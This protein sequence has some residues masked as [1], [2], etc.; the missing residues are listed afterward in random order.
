MYVFY[1]CFFFFRNA[2]AVEQ[3]CLAATVMSYRNKLNVDY[4]H[5]NHMYRM[6]TSCFHDNT[7]L[8]LVNKCQHPDLDALSKNIP[9]TSQITGYTYWNKPCAM[10]NDDNDDV[11]EWTPNV[12][13]KTN[14]PYFSNYSVSRRNIPYP[15]TYEKLSELLNS[16]RFSE[17]IYT[18]PLSIM[19]ENHICIIEKLVH[20]SNCGQTLNEEGLSTSDWLSESCSQFNSP[21]Q[22]GMRAFSMNIFCLICRNSIPLVANKQSCRTT[23]RLKAGPGYLTALFNYKL[24]PDHIALD[25]DRLIAEGKCNCDEMFDPYLV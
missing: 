9:V 23:G 8:T 3:E 14:V 17:I 13:I 19:P 22:H 25:D 1:S 10:C 4:S 5:E 20:A 11:I 18:P 15:D 21:V 16:R 6:V 12:L 7:N 24:E 2:T